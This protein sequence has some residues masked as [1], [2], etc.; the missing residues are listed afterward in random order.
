MDVAVIGGGICGLSSAYQA[1]SEKS[2]NIKQLHIYADKY[3]SQTTSSGAAGLWRAANVHNTPR[4]KL[5]RWGKDSLD[6][7]IQVLSFDPD[8]AEKGFAPAH[9]FLLSR[10]PIPDVQWA[11]FGISFVIMNEQDIRRRFPNIDPDIKYGVSFSSY[12]LECRRFLSYTTKEIEK[13]GGKFFNRKIK[14]LSE[15]SVKYDVIINCCGLGAS[16]LVGD[17]K[18]IPTRGQIIYVKAPWIKEFVYDIDV[19]DG[20][21]PYIIPNIDRCI[22]GGTKQQFNSSLEPTDYDRNWILENTKKLVPSVEKAEIIEDW[23]GIRPGRDEIRLECEIIKAPTTND[24]KRTIPV[25]HN[26]GHGANGISLSW[27]CAV[28]VIEIMKERCG[29]KS[30][31]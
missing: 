2:L 12:T 19:V 10:K 3:Q 31:L 18:M 1:L 6:H 24:P 13:L 5:N 4:E 25:I 14:S 17:D 26:Y 22:L 11:H 7:A 27:G 29:V 28:N 30:S 15:L 9:G 16:E 23:V 20:N 8:S 21:V